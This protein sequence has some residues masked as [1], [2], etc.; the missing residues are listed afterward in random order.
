MINLCDVCKRK[1]FCKLC[2]NYS[3]FCYQEGIDNAL[4]RIHS[5]G[6]DE[7]GLHEYNARRYNAKFGTRGKCKCPMCGKLFSN[8]KSVQMHMKDKHGIA[9]ESFTVVHNR[10]EVKK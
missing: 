9:R 6:Y 5:D 10:R 1:A 7:G 3:F 2:K 4:D 8:E